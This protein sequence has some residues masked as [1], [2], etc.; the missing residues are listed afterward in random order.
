VNNAYATFEEDVKGSIEDGKLAD[1][2]VLSADYLTIP[3]EQILQL[4]PMATFVGGKKVF[5]AADAKSD[6]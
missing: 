1:F 5:S 6:Y 4:R 2:V 3:E